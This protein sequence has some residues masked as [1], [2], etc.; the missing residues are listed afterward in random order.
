MRTWWPLRLCRLGWHRW[1]VAT[2]YYHQPL[3]V[4][5]RCVNRPRGERQ[6]EGM[7][8]IVLEQEGWDWAGEEN[9]P[10]LN[11]FERYG[12]PYTVAVLVVAA[13]LALCVVAL[14]IGRAT[15]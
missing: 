11:V 12:N 9:S 13:L 8:H 15:K 5:E 10:D 6:R 4:L 7:T 1:Y 3:R 2:V 14:A